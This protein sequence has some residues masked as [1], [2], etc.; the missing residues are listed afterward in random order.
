MTKTVNFPQRLV[1]KT[2]AGGFRSA[3]PAL[4]QAPD[5]STGTGASKRLVRPGVEVRDLLREQTPVKSC[6]VQ[7]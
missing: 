3:G 4:T 1:P 2:F 6:L 5:I 7:D